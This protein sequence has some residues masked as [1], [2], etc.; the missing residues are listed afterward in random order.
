MLLVPLPETDP[1]MLEGASPC[2]MDRHRMAETLLRRLGAHWRLEPGPQGHAPE[3]FIGN[4]VGDG[5]GQT[6]WRSVRPVPVPC[7]IPDKNRHHTPRQ[8]PGARL[9]SAAQRML[10]Q[11]RMLAWKQA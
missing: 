9:D 8:R 6:G 5:I 10:L 2:V 11:L 4:P 3:T 7:R 1:V